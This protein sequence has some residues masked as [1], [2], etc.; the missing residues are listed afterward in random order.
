MGNGINIMEGV[1]E[2][3][4]EREKNTKIYYTNIE[5]NCNCNILKN[6]ITVYRK[7]SSHSERQPLHYYNHHNYSDKS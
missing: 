1:A 3:L 2:E 7:Y 4:R 6:F 5:G